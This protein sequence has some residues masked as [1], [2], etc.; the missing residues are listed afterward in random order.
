MTQEEFSRRFKG[1]A[2]KRAKRRRLLRKVAVAL[3]NRGSPEAVPALTRAL[4]DPEAL[5]CGH[6][7]WALGRIASGADCPA[8]VIA[9]IGSSLV[10]R[11][12]GEEDPRVR[13]EI[14]AAL[15]S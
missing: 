1:S 12:V 11:L 15:S 3:G 10:R 13:E 6:A 8:E 14:T 9:S 7:A 4:D 5:V 2:V